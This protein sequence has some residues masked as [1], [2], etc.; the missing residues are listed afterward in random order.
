ML[1]RLIICYLIEK[2]KCYPARFEYS[3]PKSGVSINLGARYKEI[4]FGVFSVFHYNQKIRIIIDG[5]DNLVR[6]YRQGNHY[7]KISVYDEDALERIHSTF[8][9]L[10]I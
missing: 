10:I 6:F 2:T 5:V 9:E 8:C 4:P 3:N 1:A 7:R